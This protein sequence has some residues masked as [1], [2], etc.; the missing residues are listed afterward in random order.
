MQKC[1]FVIGVLIGIIVL[2]LGPAN[3]FETAIQ[4]EPIAVLPVNG[5]PQNQ[6]S[7]LVLYHGKL[8]T[9][10]DKHD[11]TIFELKIVKDTANQV[12]FLKF[13]PQK[14]KKKKRLDFEGLTIDSEG[15]FIMVSETYFR[16]A[17]VSDNGQHH[18]WVTPSFKK[19]GKKR[20]L[21]QTKG[22]YFEGITIIGDR[23][24]MCVERQPRGL[25][26]FD[27]TSEKRSAFITDTTRFPLAPG[28]VPDFTDLFFLKGRIFALQRGAQLI[29][30]IVF[31]N[32]RWVE[33]QSGT[34]GHIENDPQYHYQTMHYGRAEG[35][36]MDGDNIY[37]VLD[38]NNDSRKDDPTD[39]RP[40][41]LI[42]KNS[43]F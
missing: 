6:P 25:I 17:M 12:P 18:K 20:G 9:V 15:R 36:A 35:L 2:A 28:R 37:V 13:D 4:L 16:A 22:A 11:D 5:P 26:E 31:E 14:L 39:N 27:L 32:E 33:K 10:S 1:R 42:M 19:W 24:L 41:L 38:N 29:S 43:F 23:L 3:A 21:F 34:F 7:G 8:L 40:L 30:E